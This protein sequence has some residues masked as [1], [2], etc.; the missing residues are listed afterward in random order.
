MSGS[1][2]ATICPGFSNF[3]KSILFFFVSMKLFTGAFGA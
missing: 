3:L 1:G 2:N